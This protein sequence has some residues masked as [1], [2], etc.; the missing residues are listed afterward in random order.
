[1]TKPQ[2]KLIVFSGPSG[3]G[4]GTVRKEM[5][6]IEPRL[7]Y[8][9]SVSATTRK[10]RHDEADGREY[11]FVSREEFEEM[12]ADGSML[13]YTEYN[14]NYYGTPLGAVLTALEKGKTIFLEIEVKGAMQTMEKVPEAITIFLLPP[15]VDELL[16]RLKKRA[17]ED[18]E[19]L[20]KRMKTAEFELEQKAKYKYNILNDELQKAAQELYD[21]LA[22]ELV[23]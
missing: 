11:N 22:A 2:G 3:V 4:K 6:K 13:E 9:M 20:N 18:E 7:D 23:P 5:D 12:I 14:G 1:M 19:T 16:R 21:I 8:I 10:K 17:T 15:S